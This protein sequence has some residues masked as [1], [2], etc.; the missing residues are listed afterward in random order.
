MAEN[1]KGLSTKEKIATLREYHQPAF[2]KLGVPDALYIPKLV[3]GT[4][5]VMLFF[6]SEL[7]A[8]KD[9]YT[10]KVSQDYELRDENR[11]L[12]KWKHNPNYKDELRTKPYGQDVMYYIPFDEF[13]PVGVKEEAVKFGIPDPDADDPFSELMVRDIAAILWKKPVSQKPWLNDLIKANF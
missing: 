1:N 6:R 7:E 11:T 5:A 8:G 9:I 13:K 3:F 4:P 12:Y 10:E 2:E